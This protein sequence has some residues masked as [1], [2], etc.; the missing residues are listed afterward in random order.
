MVNGLKLERIEFMWTDN[1]AV[2]PV[3]SCLFENGWKMLCAT[4]DE[5]VFLRDIQ[6]VSIDETCVKFYGTK[7]KWMTFL[8]SDF[9][10]IQ[11]KAI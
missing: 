3:I 1:N 2:L 6:Q 8:M 9:D 11:K 4:Q 5:I 7:E 10:N